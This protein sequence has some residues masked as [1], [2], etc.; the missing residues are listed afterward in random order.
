MSIRSANVVTITLLL[1]GMA[2]SADKNPTLGDDAAALGSTWADAAK[3]PN[4]FTGMW[5]T[6]SAMV[7]ADPKLD[8]SYKN[9]TLGDDAAALGSTWADAAKMPNFF[10]GM[11]MTYSAMV[12]ADPKLDVS[13]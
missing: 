9:P 3:M 4:F 11:W 13:Y 8:V 6:Y 12:E 7:E 10:T 2:S 1:S 5:M